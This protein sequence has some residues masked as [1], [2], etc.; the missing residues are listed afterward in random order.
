MVF[1]VVD[2]YRCDVCGH[3]WVHDRHNPDSPPKPITVYKGAEKIHPII[4]APSPGPRGGGVHVA[5]PVCRQLLE[6][7]QAWPSEAEGAGN[8][9]LYWCAADG[10]WQVSDMGAIVRVETR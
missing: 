8:A 1:A 9:D 6:H 10:Y 4:E 3:V 7:V 2:Y 5:C